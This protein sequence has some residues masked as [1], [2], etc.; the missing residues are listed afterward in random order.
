MSANNSG[1]SSKQ[2]KVLHY[3]ALPS[4]KPLTLT[5]IHQIL[6]LGNHSNERIQKTLY[7]LGLLKKD[8]REWAGEQL[9]ST[10][11]AIARSMGT[12]ANT[13]KMLLN[14]QEIRSFSQLKQWWSDTQNQTEV[15][16]RNSIYYCLY[17]Y[18]EDSHGWEEELEAIYMSKFDITY[19]EDSKKV[20]QEQCKRKGYKMKGCIAKNIAMVK[21]ELVKQVQKAGRVNDEGMSFTRNRPKCKEKEDECKR[22]KKGMFYISNVN[23]ENSPKRQCMGEGKKVQY[24]ANRFCSPHIWTK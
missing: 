22:R 9:K 18:F 21:H 11:A 5:H 10:M 17:G 14:N 24:H 16:N 19:N 6:G 23:E 20:M 7:E 12:Q 3:G 2:P 15:S 4:T 13:A 1:A 8:V